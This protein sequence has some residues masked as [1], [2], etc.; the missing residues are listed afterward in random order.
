MVLQPPVAR[1]LP[2]MKLNVTLLK[3][4]GIQ[5]IDGRYGPMH[6]SGRETSD[7]TVEKR[8]CSIFHS[9]A[10]VYVEITIG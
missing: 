2:H 1:F 6:T 10:L 5:T 7:A 9:F 8:S 4:W 3:D